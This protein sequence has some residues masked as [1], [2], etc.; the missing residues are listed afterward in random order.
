MHI[1]APS[2]KRLPMHGL[3]KPF[4]FAKNYNSAAVAIVQSSNYIFKTNS[5]QN[6]FAKSGIS[7]FYQKFREKTAHLLIPNQKLYAYI[8]TRDSQDGQVVEVLDF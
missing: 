4:L 8:I 7:L 5:L 2:D 6:Y 1:L 3:E